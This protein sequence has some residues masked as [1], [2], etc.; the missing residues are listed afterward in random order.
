M[1]FCDNNLQHLCSQEWSSC[2]QKGASSRI[3]WWSVRKVFSIVSQIWYLPGICTHTTPIEGPEFSV[4]HIQACA[5]LSRKPLWCVLWDLSLLLWPASLCHVHF[6]WSSFL[7]HFSGIVG[8]LDEAHSR[9]K[10]PPSSPGDRCCVYILEGSM[11]S[12]CVLSG[13]LVSALS[14][15]KVKTPSYISVSDKQ[16]IMFLV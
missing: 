14:Q 7:T 5:H 8:P 2:F 4:R 15:I 13:P 11:V 9:S 12:P 10:G 3:G 6:V 1:S 16:W